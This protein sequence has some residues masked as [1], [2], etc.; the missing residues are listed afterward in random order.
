VSQSELTRRELLFYL[1]A[2]GFTAGQGLLGCSRGASTNPSVEALS[3]SRTELESAS[4]V[5]RLWL[6]GQQ[7]APDLAE[8]VRVLSEKLGHAP[9]RLPPDALQQALGRL[10]RQDFAERRITEASGWVLSETE[11]RLYAILHLGSR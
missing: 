8:L 10:H 2:A 1:A 11:A 7:G 3:G 6:E 5:G 9:D 4:E